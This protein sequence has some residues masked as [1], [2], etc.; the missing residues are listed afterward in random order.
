MN[1]KCTTIRKNLVA[2]LD[3][4]L[5]ERK[6]QALQ[7]HLDCCKECRAELNELRASQATM[8]LWQDI[9]PSEHY[10]RIFEQKLAML[11]QDL[12]AAKE[13]SHLLTIVRHCFNTRFA[14]ATSAVLAVCIVM[15]SIVA[16]KQYRKPSQHELGISR[17]IE[18][19]RNMEVIQYSEALEHFD[20]IQVLDVLGQET[21]G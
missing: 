17:D 19:Y 11:K 12:A 21:T 13:K 5:S 3:R 18:L 15:L 4:Q 1:K 8:L 9:T 2:Y 14:L 6:K 7:E 10:D 16:F 20:M